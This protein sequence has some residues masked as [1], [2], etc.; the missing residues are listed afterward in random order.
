MG[1]DVYGVEPQ[2][3]TGKYFRNNIWWWRPLANYIQSAAPT[4]ALP[5]QL[6][7][8]ND[9]D[10]LTKEQTKRLVEKL[11]SLIQDGS[12]ERFAVDREKWLDGLPKEST[13]RY[14]GFSLDN[15]KE[16][17]EFLRHCGGFTIC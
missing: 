2:N 4:E 16:F 12:I 15:V 14:Y 1:M 7:H 8:S 11:D 10:G 9:G 13:E 6:W 5:C 17:T 3:E